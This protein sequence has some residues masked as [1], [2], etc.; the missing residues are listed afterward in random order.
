ML[1]EWDG[2]EWAPLPCFSCL[3]L[4]LLTFVC[5]LPAFGW[6]VEL[7]ITDP[8]RLSWETSLG[9]PLRERH[10]QRPGAEVIAWSFTHMVRAPVP[11]PKTYKER[12]E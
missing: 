1:T 12:H 8:R 7:L 9:I 10:Q 3:S 5:T 6:V 4:L 11:K 2:R